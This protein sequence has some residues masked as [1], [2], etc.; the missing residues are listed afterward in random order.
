[1]NLGYSV[2]GLQELLQSDIILPRS[3]INF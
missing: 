1:M 2:L 3:I